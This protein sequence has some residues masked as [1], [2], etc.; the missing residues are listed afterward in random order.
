MDVKAPHKAGQF[1]VCDDLLCEVVDPPVNWRLR[2]PAMGGPSGPAV[3]VSRGSV[4]PAACRSSPRVALLAN[5][6]WPTAGTGAEFS[7]G[8]VPGVQ[9]RSLWLHQAGVRWALAAPLRG[10]SDAS[11][12]PRT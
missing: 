4:G 7:R 9:R 10:S 2:A 5:I 6:H 12:L 3:S 1:S 8:T 11:P